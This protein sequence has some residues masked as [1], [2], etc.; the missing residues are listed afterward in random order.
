MEYKVVP[1]H[2]VGI[3]KPQKVADGYASIINS[4][5][6][7]GWEFVCFEDIVSST[8]CGLIKTSIK[9]LVFRK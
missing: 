1:G 4:E 5:A 2:Q 6:T 8:C 3:G 9:M 7:N